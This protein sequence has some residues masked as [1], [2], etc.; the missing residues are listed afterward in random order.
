MY[1][2]LDSHRRRIAA[3]AS[4]GSEDQLNPLMPEDIA[5]ALLVFDS[6]I[7]NGTG[8]E[9]YYID[10]NDS[11]FNSLPDGGFVSL[12]VKRL[13]Y[14]LKIMKYFYLADTDRSGIKNF[15]DDQ[16]KDMTYFGFVGHFRYSDAEMNRNNLLAAV[17]E[18]ELN[19]L[20]DET[21]GAVFGVTET[22]D[23]ILD[24]DRKKKNILRKVYNRVTN[25][26][27]PSKDANTAEAKERE[28]AAVL[29]NAVCD[30]V[31]D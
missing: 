10:A 7:R 28:F 30:A 2:G 6:F 14:F 13:S 16:V 12:C 15:Y 19:C 1:I 21:T 11:A 23:N 9:G 17:E 27:R 3:K 26:S 18:L 29:W 24:I 4:N 5:A 31:V 8:A 25:H 22:V 20:E